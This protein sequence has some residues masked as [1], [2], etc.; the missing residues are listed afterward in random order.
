VWKRV[1]AADL[2]RGD[3]VKLSLSGVVASDMQLV[4]G[5]ILF[6]Q[7]MLTGESVPIEVG[8]GAQA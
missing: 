2:V 7:S 3:V 6:D 1:N 4:D 5:E 8:A